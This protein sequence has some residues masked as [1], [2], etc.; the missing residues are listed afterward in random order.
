MSAA[1]Q[2]ALLAARDVQQVYRVAGPLGRARLVQALRGVSL[3]VH[4]GEIVGLVGESGCGKSTLARTLLQM[5]GPAAGC[6]LYRG[7]VIGTQGAAQRRFRRDLQMVFQDPYGSLNSKWKVAAIV[8]EP[9]IGFNLGSRAE[10][11]QRAAAL[12][13]RVGLDP[14]IYGSRRPGE[15]SGGQCQRVAIARALAPGP[16]LIICDEAT[17]SL[18]PLVQQE[19]LTLFR[20]LHT[21]LSLSYLFISHDLNVVARLSHRVAVMHSGRICEVGACSSIYERPAHPY[22]A[23]LVEHRKDPLRCFADSADDALTGRPTV[24]AAVTDG[25]SFRHRCPHATARC[26]EL[27]PQAT[28]IS[29]G[30]W[31]ACHHPLA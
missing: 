15:L 16:S 26:S 27:T 28:Q 25:C 22:T 14:A 19:T 24:A 5:P 29:A 4:Q 18:D 11:R 30:H 12:L 13:E 17:A 20:E 9:L 1:C 6:I 10:R 23:E 3:E 8:E 21:Q 2:E 31:V 7:N